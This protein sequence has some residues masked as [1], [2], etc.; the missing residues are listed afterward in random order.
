MLMNYLG[1]AR[2]ETRPQNKSSVSTVVRH[3]PVQS[4]PGDKPKSLPS[5]GIH[6]SP[7]FSATSNLSQLAELAA[8]K[9]AINQTSAALTQSAVQPAMLP[10]H[11][12]GSASRLVIPS[13]N[14]H[15][16]M[17]IQPPPIFGA[18]PTGSVVHMQAT[19]QY[20]GFPAPSPQ[21]PPPFLKGS[22]IQLASGEL[23][24][25]EDLTTD[26]FIQSTR[27][28]SDLKLETST[29]VKIED[30]S[31]AGSAHITFTINSSKAQVKP[32]WQNE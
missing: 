18:Y 4:N 31:D 24:R 21:V 14:V 9:S 2:S 7:G 32:M 10:P 30:G 29:V 16:S 3:L 13:Q 25:V 26:D 1:T 12:L 19:G 5:N 20:Q 22:I 17:G 23:K 8:N 11:I 27:L 28:C 15:P 6:Y